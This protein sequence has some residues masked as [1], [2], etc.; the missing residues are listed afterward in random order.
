MDFLGCNART[1]ERFP[2]KIILVEDIER[3]A[4]SNQLSSMLIFF[5]SI[6]L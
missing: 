1:R 6:G 3:T 4:D 2:M 5:N